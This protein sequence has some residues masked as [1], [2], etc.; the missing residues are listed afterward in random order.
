MSGEMGFY[1]EPSREANVVPPLPPAKRPWARLCGYGANMFGF[2]SAHT[3]TLCA[4]LNTKPPHA[5]HQPFLRHRQH[6]PGCPFLRS[7]L[8]LFLV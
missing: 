5:S 3:L 2:F 6:L 1:T 8:V 7:V 4:E